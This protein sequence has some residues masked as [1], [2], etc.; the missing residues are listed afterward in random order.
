MLVK[1]S[2]KKFEL[3]KVCAYISLISIAMSEKWVI[4]FTMH[5]FVLNVINNCYEMVI[6]L[7]RRQSFATYNTAS[8]LAG[9]VD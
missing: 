5:N 8:Q 9:F 4:L 6:K 1:E 3:S 2:T 7:F